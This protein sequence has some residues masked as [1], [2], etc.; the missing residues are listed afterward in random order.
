MTHLNDR[1]V[2]HETR[3]V[4][5]GVAIPIRGR[6]RGTRVDQDPDGILLAVVCGSVQRRPPGLVNPVDGA[7]LTDQELDHLHGWLHRVEGAWLNAWAMG[8]AFLSSP[9]Y[10]IAVHECGGVHGESVN[11]ITFN[12]CLH[13]VHA[14]MNRQDAAELFSPLYDPWLRPSEWGGHP[15]HP[16][17]RLGL[18]HQEELDRCQCGSLQ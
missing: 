13:G 7:L 4:Q 9:C 12:P 3:E 5:R 1:Q 14:C 18:W 2:I 11:T 15:H 6:E 10:E 16:R 17:G 8:H